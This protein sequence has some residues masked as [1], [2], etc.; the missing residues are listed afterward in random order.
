M[1]K[2]VVFIATL[3]VLTSLFA[4]VTSNKKEQVRQRR[5]PPCSACKIFINSF[6]KG[7][8]RTAKGHHAGGD[9]AWEEQKLGSYSKSEIR[10]V[11]IQE[12]VCLDVEEGRD[13]CYALHEEHDAIIEEWWFNL[14]DEKPNIYEYFCIEKL[15][16]CCPD[17]HYGANCT[18]CAGFPD[19]ICNNNGKCKG[20][21]TR[22]G[23][24]QCACDDGYAGVTCNECD[25]KSY[26]AYR[27]DKKLLCSPCPIYC[28]GACTKEGC[29]KCAPG[30]IPGAEPGTCLDINE[31]AG[32]KPVC[33]PLQFCVNTDGS[34]RCLECDKACTGCIGDGPDMCLRCAKG[35]RMV[36]KIC[37]DEDKENRHN[38]VYW[39]RIITYLGLC[40]CTCI[41]LQRNVV[42]AGIIGL[43]VAVYIAV[44][45]Y[46]LNSPP[47]PISAEIPQ[48]FFQDS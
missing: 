21:G 20:S 37:I 7:M 31:C 3:V 35:F 11:E 13:Q 12:K 5:Y 36:D 32:P 45:E 15:Q 16:H 9:T 41:I 27:D 29:E 18:P 34:Y 28:D 38:Y 4:I 6:K 1:S 33:T 30:W 2:F 24:G 47:T 25:N 40:V 23:S 42:L 22:K 26:E 43:C 10:L 39:T 44:S 17:H 8:D 19:N 46:I 48:R 14:Q